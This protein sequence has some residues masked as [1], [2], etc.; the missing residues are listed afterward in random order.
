MFKLNRMTDYA[1]VVL[2]ALA[3]RRGEILAVA[4]LA[5]LTGINQPTVAKVATMHV[6]ADLLDTQGGVHG[7]YPL[8]LEAGIISLVQIV[9]A[10]EG[11]IAVTQC[12]DGAKAPAAW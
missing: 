1:I 5:G 9:E 3:R 6:A 4:Q 10:M 8:S 12:V 2:G 7:G 11:P